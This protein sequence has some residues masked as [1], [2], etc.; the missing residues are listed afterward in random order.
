ML[1]IE[2]AVV[3]SRRQQE[4]TNIDYTRHNMLSP[5]IAA[6]FSKEVRVNPERNIADASVPTRSISGSR[7]SPSGGNTMMKVFGGDDEGDDFEMGGGTENQN[8]YNDI[9]VGEGVFAFMVFGFI[10]MLFKLR[11]RDVSVS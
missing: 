8:F 9:P 2:R 5:N 10:Y 6:P 3:A 11:K 7:L 4:N 1:G